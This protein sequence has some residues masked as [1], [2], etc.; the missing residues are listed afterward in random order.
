MQRRSSRSVIAILAVL[1]ATLSFAAHAQTHEKVLYSFTGTPDGENPNA[2]VISDTAG[3]LYGTTSGGGA[4][5]FGSVFE[6][7]RGSGGTWSEKVIYSFQGTPDGA[8]PMDSLVFDHAGNLYGT[9]AFGGDYNGGIVFE[10]TPHVDG[11]WTEAILF[12]S[13]GSTPADHMVANLIF[14]A[15]GNLYGTSLQGGYGTGDVFKMTPNTDGSWTTTE[16]YL[17]PYE[18]FN[19][20][21]SGLLIDSAGNLYG[22]TS[23]GGNNGAGNAFE[24]SLSGGVWYADYLHSF[25]G[26]PDGQNP[27]AALIF[28]AAG[29]LYGTTAG[30]GASSSCSCGTV[31]RLKPPASGRQ[32]TEEVLHSFT[33]MPGYS[34]NAG[35][36]LD[37]A[38]N[39]YGVTYYTFGSNNFQD[40]GGSAFRINLTTG[41]YSVLHQ[42]G[43]AG[44][45]AGPLGTLILGPSGY[46]YGTTYVGGSSPVY[47]YGTVFELQP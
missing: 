39:L 1:F 12:N 6:L 44:D 10:L 8:T 46:L 17:F 31:F 37:S 43:N 23:S 25:K 42:F 40:I 15:S 9:T 27:N 34:P 36:V 7:I 28:D 26:Y 22:T 38:N 41:A 18:R 3:N 13:P 21:N 2:G 33:D 30:G 20:P 32:W 29:N 19:N 16:I 5:G 11:T 14:D 4:A 24:I 35:L 47:G 45:G